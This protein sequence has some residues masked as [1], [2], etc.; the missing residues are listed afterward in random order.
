MTKYYDADTKTIINNHGDGGK[1]FKK[2]E[3]R[4]LVTELFFVC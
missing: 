3:G 1:R 2:R 4:L